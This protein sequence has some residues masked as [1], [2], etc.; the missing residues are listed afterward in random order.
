MY[1]L[2]GHTHCCV[3][4]DG[5]VILDVRSGTYLGIDSEY[6]PT[7][8]AS[9]VDWPTAATLLVAARPQSVDGKEQLLAD[10]CKRQLLATSASSKHDVHLPCP[11]TSVST[12]GCDALRRNVPIRHQALFIVALL[13]VLLMRRKDRLGPIT[14]WIRRR[15]SNVKHRAQA[16]AERIAYLLSSFERLRIW[17]YTANKHCL[18]DS[19]V[20]SVFLTLARQPCFFVIAVSIKPFLAHSWVQIDHAVLNDTV[21]H[22]QLFHPLLVIG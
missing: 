9:V 18:L 12:V 3:F 14:N 5:A 19:L 15:Q 22:V 21:E 11:Q 2:S 4:N 13:R 17:F 7:L 6:L 20:L 8:V 10:L 16:D 1:Y